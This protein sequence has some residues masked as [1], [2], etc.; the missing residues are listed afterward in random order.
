MQWLGMGS[1][2]DALKPPTSWME[3]SVCQLRSPWELVESA[4]RDFHMEGL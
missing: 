2:H 4:Q 3:V 1:N